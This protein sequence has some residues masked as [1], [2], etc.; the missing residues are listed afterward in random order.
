MQ[1]PLINELLFCKYFV[2]L[3]VG[4]VTK[5]FATY[6]CFN[7][8]FIVTPCMCAAVLATFLSFHLPEEFDNI[9]RY[10]NILFIFLPEKLLDALYARFNNSIPQTE[11]YHKHL[12]KKIVT[13]IVLD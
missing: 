12:K 2:R 3:S 8:C 6:E 9:I 5:G 13:F 10:I 11:K 7:P 1:I 4:N